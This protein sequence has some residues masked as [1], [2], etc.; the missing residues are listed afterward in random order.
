MTWWLALISRSRPWLGLAVQHIR[1]EVG[2]EPFGE[3]LATDAI[4]QPTLNAHTKRHVKV[5]GY[6]PLCTE[7]AEHHV[8][9]DN[10]QLLG[11]S[12]VMAGTPAR[13]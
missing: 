10:S 12:V 8:L 4:S 2:R 1:V 3:L 7:R 5:T 9:R 6:H 11:D 13:G